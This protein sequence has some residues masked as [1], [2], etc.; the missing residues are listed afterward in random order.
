MNKTTQLILLS[1]LLL[2]PAARAADEIRLGNGTTP[3]GGPKG[4]I[5]TVKV[6]VRDLSGSTLNVSSGSPNLIQG[7]AFRMTV[8]P[9]SAV[10]AISSTRLGACAA[11]SPYSEEFNDDRAGASGLVSYYA[12]YTSPL[13][14]TENLAAPGNECVLLRFT[15]STTFHGTINLTLDPAEIGTLLAGA[16]AVVEEST[17]NGQLSLVN[18]TIVVP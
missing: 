18:S 5:S 7:L 3:F 8:S 14:L 15:I 1:A 11:Q 10:T 16:D 12:Q 6:Y 9:S 13:A 2:S 4:K 17:A